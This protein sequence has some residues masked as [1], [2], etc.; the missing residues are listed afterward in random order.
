[1]AYNVRVV[2]RLPSG[3][4]ISFVNIRMYEDLIIGLQKKRPEL[5]RAQITHWVHNPNF[6]YDICDS[7]REALTE[8]LEQYLTRNRISRDKLYSSIPFQPHSA[9]FNFIDLFAGIGGFNLGMH[10]QGG[11][12]V[13]SSEWDK[14]AQETYFKNYGK[15]PFGDINYFTAEEVSDEDINRR[16]PDHHIL[17][18]GFPCQPFSLAGVS[19]RTSRGIAHG[20]E[21]DTQGTLF[22]SIARIAYVKQPEILFLENVKNIVGHNSGETFRVIRETLEKLAAG[23]EA[24]HNYV[25]NY[26]I[27]N[28]QTLVP[29]R[30]ERCFMV[31]IRADVYERLGEYEF[32]VFDGDS[33]PLSSVLEQLSQDEQDE[34][35]ISD[36]LWQGHINRTKRN[37]ERKT[38]FTANLA[39]LNA[40]SNTIVARYG[41][42]GKEC[43]V[44]QGDGLNPRKLTKKECARLFGYPENFQFPE[45]KTPTYK[46]LGNSVVVPVVETISQ[47]IIRY[48]GYHQT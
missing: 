34:Y 40:P 32:P 38:G 19:A 9:N 17:C 2:C 43:L 29:Q 47:S 3:G 14:T 21:C 8:F 45:A 12:C 5:S 7:D 46:L 23:A 15:F 42:D 11:A 1:M 48:L 24:K 18:G 25:F 28:S 27:V 10:R 13:F 26:A 39:N 37:L 4:N 33:M 22:Y 16:I 36:K 44:P 35:T 41:K 30:R 6:P 31:C 20:F